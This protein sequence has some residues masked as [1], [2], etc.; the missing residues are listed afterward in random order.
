MLR[1]GTRIK[2]TEDWV[3]P[4]IHF[5]EYTK[6]ILKRTEERL[7]EKPKQ[8]KM[9]GKKD[10]IQQ[11]EF[12]ISKINDINVYCDIGSLTKDEKVINDLKVL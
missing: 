11:E 10:I 9:S 8:N 5:E 1:Q 12:D 7:K 6:E 4:T 2:G 3:F